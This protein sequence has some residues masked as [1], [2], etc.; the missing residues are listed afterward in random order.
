MRL[1]F[2][3]THNFLYEPVLVAGVIEDKPYPLIPVSL[4]NGSRTFPTY[5]LLD[6]GA[7]TCLFHGDFARSIGLVVEEGRYEPIGGIDPE[8]QIDAYVHTIDLTIGDSYTLRCEVAFSDEIEKGPSD[9]LIG[10]AAVFDAL[11]FAVRQGALKVHIGR[12]R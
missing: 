9:Q 2:G 10:R 7:D 11:R 1:T 8:S 4:A 5:A 3:E 6:T 12:E